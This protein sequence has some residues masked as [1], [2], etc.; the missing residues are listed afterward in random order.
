MKKTMKPW[1]IALIVVGII[2]LALVSTYNSLARAEVDVEGAWAQVETV[3]QRRA[4]LIPQLV[5]VAEGAAQFEKSTLESVTAARTNWLN[6]GSLNAKV[7]AAKEMDSA[8][9]AL[10]ATFEAYPTL[11][12][13]QAFI[14]MQSSVEGS[15]NRIAVERKR[16]NDSVTN[17]NKMIIVFP[18]NLVATMFGFDE[19]EFFESNEGADQAPEIEFNIE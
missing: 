13:T 4:D 1:A 5:S 15:E 17:F 14:D 7:S 19:K 9:G 18:K 11:T 8:L 10:L 12:A 6:A 3:Y 16:F 2:L